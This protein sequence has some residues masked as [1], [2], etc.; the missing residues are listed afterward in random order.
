M[1]GLPLFSLY[2]RHDA[3]HPAAAGVAS[4]QFASISGGQQNTASESG[5]S[6]QGGLN[7]TAS[8]GRRLRSG[9]VTL[10]PDL[11]LWRLAQLAR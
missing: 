4:N 1:R 6:V 11:P 9:R 5:A 2:A 7:R 10:D 3:G 8:G